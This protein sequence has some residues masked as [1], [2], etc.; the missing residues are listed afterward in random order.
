MNGD[1]RV[2]GSQTEAGTAPWPPDCCPAP[3]ENPAA[4][5]C[6]SGPGCSAESIAAASKKRQTAGIFNERI[7]I[8]K[9]RC[10]GI[11]YSSIRDMSEHRSVLRVQVPFY[12][13]RPLH[14]NAAEQTL[15]QDQSTYQRSRVDIRAGAESDIAIDC[16]PRVSVTD[17]SLTPSG[18]L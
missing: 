1:P 11:L 16:E 3:P 9:L 10:D 2:A 4:E 18:T 13:S 14:H 15:T 12:R 5:G 8:A 17:W 6:A 7:F